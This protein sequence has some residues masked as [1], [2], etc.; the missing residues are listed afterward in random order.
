VRPLQAHVIPLDEKALDE[1][2]KAFFARQL[3]DKSSHVVCRS[4]FRSFDY[5]SYHWPCPAWAGP[6]RFEVAC[7]CGYGRGIN[8]RA[9][10]V[11]GDPCPWC[12]RLWSAETI[13]EALAHPERAVTEGWDWRNRR[14]AP[15]VKGSN[16]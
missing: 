3:E 15:R 7:L 1:V 10:G 6:L 14:P 11:P 16:V 4:C 8:S 2:E 13:A 9:V 12:G 5:R